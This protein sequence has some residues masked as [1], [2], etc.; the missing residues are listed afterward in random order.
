MT[1][2][3]FIAETVHGYGMSHV[4][5]MPYIGPGTLM[6]MEKLGIKR[7]QTHGEKAA[8]YMADAYA[9]VKR[10][11]GL[12]MAQSVG[13]VNLAAGLQDAFLACSPVIALTGR[14]LQINQ[15]R[16]AYQEVDHVS[17]FSAV[18]K[19]NAFVANPE[20]LPIY[21]RQAFRSATS[22]T[23]GPV[24]LDF[25]GIAGQAVVDSEADLEVVIEEMFAHV[26]AF[27]PI[28][29]PERIEEALHLLTEAKRPVIVAGGG[30]AAS[31]ARAE[32]VAL[33]E[34]LSV[35][36]ATA[37]NAKA[38]FPADHPLAVGTPGSYSRA[39][40]NQVLCEADLVFF[41]G[42]HAGGQVTHGKAVSIAAG[43]TRPMVIS[44]RTAK[45]ECGSTIGAYVVVNRGGWILTAGHLLDIV[46]QHQDSARRYEGYRGNVVEFHRDIAADKRYRAKGVRTFHQPAASSVRNHSVWWG[47]DGVRLIEARIMPAADL[48]LGRL[49]P[50]DAAAVARYPV[51]KDPARGHAPGR[52][53]CKLGFPLHRIEPVYDE[54]AATFTL[55]EG[56]V[57]L[58][59]LPLEGMFTRVV[60]TRAPGSVAGDPTPFIETSS[61]SL[62]GQMGGPVFDADA[63][64]W[65]IQSHTVHHAL[66]F[67]PPVPGGA[68]GKVEHQFL[69]TGLA[70]HARTVR[71][72]LDAEGIE[73]ERESRAGAPNGRFRE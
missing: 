40:A 6:E 37:L 73:Y 48:A 4:F 26:P 3:R 38:M 25:E 43:F 15:Q 71:G 30:V 34:K 54:K 52:S 55:P 62:I 10:G 65:G 22:G 51:F 31:D 24:H 13:A 70:V 12:C 50:F 20:Q 19:F 8:A 72:L 56:S 44:W 28:A 27:R 7:V 29:E 63:V 39:C 21:L 35:P 45:G 11:P 67:R 58:P 60:N 61:P 2:G 23:P 17:P 16:H 68:A 69:N 53:L 1:G 36:V 33:A 57:P 66:G 64:V 47:T 32:V 9:R 59:M 49:E 46:R 41:I 42:S 18:T 14:E 5:F